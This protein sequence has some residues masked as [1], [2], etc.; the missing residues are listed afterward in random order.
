MRTLADFAVDAAWRSG[1]IALAAL[2]AMP[3]LRRVRGALRHALLVA[4]LVA[5]ACV[6]F[7][8]VS[9][10]TGGL[11]P[12]GERRAEVRRA[13]FVVIAGIYGVLTT[14]AAFVLAK[15]IA[16]SER[17]RRR[18]K[19][20]VQVTDD[21]TTP[22][23]VGIF[24]PVVLIPR[25]LP[26]SLR[27]AV[28]GHELAHVRRRDTLL[29]LIVELI[30]LPVAFHPLVQRL[31]RHAATARELACDDAVT[32]S[33]VAPRDYAR[34]LLGVAGTPADAIA[35]G[36]AD[37]LETR[38]LALRT[39]IPRRGIVAAL[40]GAAIVAVVAGAVSHFPLTLFG[41]GRSGFNGA[42]VLDRA[43]TQF[44]PIEP[45]DAFAQ[46]LGFDGKRLT[47]SQTR[48]R[49][50]HAQY[51]GWAVRTDGV[52]RPVKVDGLHGHENARWD[53]NALLLDLRTTGHSE[54]TR[55]FLA[56][57]DTLVC[58]GHIT[59]GTYRFVFRRKEAR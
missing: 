27:R 11:Q 47:S 1:A 46:S 51:V 56:D 59:K 39:P 30:T 18:A 42:W 34:A 35:F 44:G 4:V 14:R 50:G 26:R 29:Q 16:R 17:L 55:A 37:A 58:E 20:R 12:A 3:L 43:A 22:V 25:A 49:R 38:L 57:P 32:A 7:V 5:C 24:S 13:A 31:K 53:G 6:P 19:K 33:H 48:V 15:A 54:Q 45:Y 21:V 10:W 36:A 23:T 41:S 2:A 9:Q 40:L 28:L 52:T 8:N